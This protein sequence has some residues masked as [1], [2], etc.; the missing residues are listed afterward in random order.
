[1]LPGIA[2]SHELPLAESS[3]YAGWHMLAGHTKIIHMR[4]TVLF[5]RCICNVLR[6]PLC[7]DVLFQIC[8]CDIMRYFAIFIVYCFYLVDDD[9]FALVVAF[10]VL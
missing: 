8:V 3:I 9:A 1:V 5:S 4:T 2:R 10:G 7:S 6:R